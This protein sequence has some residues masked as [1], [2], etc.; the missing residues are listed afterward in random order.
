VRTALALAAL[1]TAAVAQPEA[2][3]V[4]YVD[5]SL[6]LDGRLLSFGFVDLRGDGRRDL[7]LAVRVPAGHREL[8]VHPL[9][10]GRLAS[11]PE[12]TVPVLD[13]VL[14]W[15]V[16]NVR[17]EPGAELLFLT[18]GGAWSYS[19]AHPGY[20]DNVRR[21]ASAELVYDMP[22]PRALLR[23]E[24]VIPGGERDLV[25]LPGRDGVSL[26]GPSQEGDS[27][28]YVHR[29]AFGAS[30]VDR[31]GRTAGGPREGDGGVEVSETR[32]RSSPF[33]R[34]D[35]A[36]VAAVL[37]GSFY[38]RAPALVDLDGDG[39]TDFVRA[40]ERALVIHLGRPSGPVE[41]PARIEQL[42]EDLVSDEDT[43]VEL[44]LVDVDADGVLDLLAHVAEE[45][46]GFENALHRLLLY[47]GETGRLLR[48]R[49]DQMLRFEAAMLSVAVTDVDG[50]GRPDLALRKLE[51]P[52]L[53]GTV[54]GLEFTF[55]HFVYLGEGRGFARKPA[56]SRE[57]TYDEESVVELA[58]NRELV[59]DCDGDGIADLVEIDLNGDIAIRRVRVES[60]FLR[61][62]EWVLEAAPWKH[63]DVD[64]SIASLRVEDLNGD[65]LGDIVSA[66]DERL[67]VL[68]SAR[69]GGRR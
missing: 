23:W 59:L 18:R 54:T 39:F 2:D 15:G 21:L 31:G 26:F 61:G 55:G 62:E 5:S 57:E 40:T 14:A 48:E 22:D 60:S 58:A 66:G 3:E 28:E 68:L 12:T 7:V 6:D 20:R 13:D 52:S 17:D 49:P 69:R 24:Y 29:S 4:Y 19:L 25:L 38:Y 34:D 37:E 42:P 41:A 16:A 65:G 1:S 36:G 27:D 47:R 44:M 9:R 51:L 10:E 56:L 11:E 33:L 32:D 63:F 30:P 64:G 53:V 8:R 46:D 50:D 67:I 35:P 45:A 43:E